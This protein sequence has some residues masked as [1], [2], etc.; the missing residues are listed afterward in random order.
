MDDYNFLLTDI[1]NE[2]M[3]FFNMIVKKKFNQLKQTCDDTL[4]KLDSLKKLIPE[5]IPEENNNNNLDN[6]K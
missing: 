6:L 5:N 2:Y 3:K 4:K 1:E